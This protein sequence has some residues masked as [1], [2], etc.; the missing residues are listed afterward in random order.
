MTAAHE[1]RLSVSPEEELLELYL[2]LPKKQREERFINTAHAAEL[3]G[4][5]VRTIQFWIENGTVRA[6]PIGK[7]YR[8]DLISLR[9]H[10]K[11]QVEKRR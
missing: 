5:A 4:L 3:T 8:V 9:E 7:K 1:L 10:L 6:V 2:S 11:R